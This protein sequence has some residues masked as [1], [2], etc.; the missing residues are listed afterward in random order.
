MS[1]AT[2]CDQ[3][4]DAPALVPSRSARFCNTK[5]GLDMSIN[6]LIN[7]EISESETK[8]QTKIGPKKNQGP[9]INC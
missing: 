9:F 5:F 4:A 2:M 7:P 3:A 6:K 8:Y 1:P